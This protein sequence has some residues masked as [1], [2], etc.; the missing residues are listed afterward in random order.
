MKK[1]TFTLILL[2][3]SLITNAQVNIPDSNFEGALVTFGMDTDGVVNGQISTADA[4]AITNLSVGSQNV[5]DLTGINSFTNLTYFACDNNTNLQSFYFNI[6][7]LETLNVINA[8]ITTIDLSGLPNLKV[9]Y[10]DNNSNMSAL[11]IT[12][13]AL[14]ETV[15]ARNCNLS[16]V[17]PNTNYPYLDIRLSNNNITGDIDL[18]LLVNAVTLDFS[19]NML[20]SIDVTGLTDLSFLAVDNCN[21]SDLDVTTNINLTNL[22]AIGNDFIC[23]DLS[24]NPLLDG[25]EVGN[26]AYANMTIAV[27]DV[28]AA[29]AATG[30]Y[31]WWYKDATATYGTT[32]GTATVSE[33][34]LVS[35]INI[36]PNPVIDTLNIIST[37]NATYTMYDINGRAILNGIIN[38]GN[39]TLELSYF[40]SGI[41]FLKVM[42][43]DKY[44]TKR[45]I[46]K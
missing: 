10:I 11:D 39:N 17:Q 21:L 19:N 27:S 28:T 16:S 15:Y 7:N 13:N 8:N 32:C 23:L 4:L 44:L 30:I 41:Y 34:G 5:T 36:Y 37:Q 12:T 22:T 2:T 6:P 1:F 3:I 46:L 33:N 24:Q 18:T 29:N 45:I 40:D 31:Q 38:I 20:N 26:N 42:S 25:V 43:Q 14:L 35:T 9:L